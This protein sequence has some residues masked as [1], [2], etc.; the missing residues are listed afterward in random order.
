MK[1]GNFQYIILAA[2]FVICLS[3]IAS[4]PKPGEQP[5]ICYEKLFERSLMDKL[6]KI[7][8]WEAKRKG[9]SVQGY[10]G[11]IA[12]EYTSQKTNRPIYGLRFSTHACNTMGLDGGGFDIEVDPK[13]FEVIDSYISPL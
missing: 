11:F 6:S 4:T 3:A 12:V 2:V 5:E 8:F 7:A 13:T 9:V 1:L 10:A